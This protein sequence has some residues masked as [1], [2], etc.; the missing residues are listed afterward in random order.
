MQRTQSDTP[1]RCS[2]SWKKC[3][4]GSEVLWCGINTC[5]WLSRGSG[6]SDV[7]HHEGKPLA[8]LFRMIWRVKHLTVAGVG[9]VHCRREPGVS[10]ITRAAGGE[11]TFS[12]LFFFFFLG[13]ES[14]MSLH[15]E[16][17]WCWWTLSAHQTPWGEFYRPQWAEHVGDRQKHLTDLALPQ[18]LEDVGQGWLGGVEVAGLS[19]RFSSTHLQGCR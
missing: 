11:G 10:P 7:L 8:S 13:G 18:V 15:T 2:H 5:V 14:L 19:G 4:R 16:R 6:G 17:G 1:G 9:L 12:F 3:D